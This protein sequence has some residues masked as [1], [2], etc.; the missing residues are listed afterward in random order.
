MVFPTSAFLGFVGLTK[1]T[2]DL[3]T[4]STYGCLAAAIVFIGGCVLA[5][6][7]LGRC[8]GKVSEV[9]LKTLFL[10]KAP[11]PVRAVQ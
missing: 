3:P 7:V 4:V 8:I 5:E 10:D 1:C 6:V 9:V 11:K 2:E